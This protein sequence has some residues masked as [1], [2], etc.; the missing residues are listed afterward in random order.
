MEKGRFMSYLNAFAIA[1][2]YL[3]VTVKTMIESKFSVTNKSIEI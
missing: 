1:I 2:Q 3:A